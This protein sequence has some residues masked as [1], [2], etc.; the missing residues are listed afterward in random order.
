M[1]GGKWIPRWQLD[2]L[3]ILNRRKTLKEYVTIVVSLTHGCSQRVFIIPWDLLVNAFLSKLSEIG[4]SWQAFADD[5][6]I[7]ARVKFEEALYDLV[8]GGFRLAHN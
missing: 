7:C 6:V 5:I 4:K 1:R 2:I 8:R 3:E